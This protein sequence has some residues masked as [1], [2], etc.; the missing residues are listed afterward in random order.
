[1]KYP[2]FDN[3][4]FSPPLAL[5]ILSQLQTSSSFLRLAAPETTIYGF[6]INLSISSAS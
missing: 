4:P 6:R 2:L 3:Q 1:M 5:L